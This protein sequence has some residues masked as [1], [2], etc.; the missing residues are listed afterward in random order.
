[1][2][3]AFAVLASV[4]AV[5]APDTPTRLV[6]VAIV[7]GAVPWLVLASRTG[8]ELREDALVVRGALRTRAY[9]WPRID[10]AFVVRRM[11]RTTLALRLT[12]GDVHRIEQ[13]SATGAASSLVVEAAAAISHRVPR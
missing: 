7:A 1:M 13:L 8:V 9:A 2:P 10:R 5:Q 11:G 6:S 12:D 3:G 4:V